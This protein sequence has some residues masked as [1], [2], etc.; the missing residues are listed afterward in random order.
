MQDV[1][2]LTS[3]TNAGVERLKSDGHLDKLRRWL[4]PSDPSTNL[5]AA[6]GKRLEGTGNWFIN[7][8]AFSQ[9]KSGSP[10]HLWL[11]GLAGCGKT[12]LTS[13]ILDHLHSA[14]TDSCVCL[15]FF[16]DFR[17]KDKQHLDNLLRSLASQLYARCAESRQELDSLFA[18]CENG[19]MQPTIELLSKTV[20]LMMQ[21]PQK[22]RIVL[23]A[24]DECAAR[25][26]LLEWMKTLAGPALKNVHLIAT[27]RREE[28]L[29]SGLQWIDKENTI[30]LQGDLIDND[31]RSYTKARLQGPGAFQKRWGEKLDV[32][33]E[34]ETVI[35]EKSKG[36]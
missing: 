4:S 35:G 10:Q 1:H 17:D 31:I 26:E 6:R 18:S 14:P 33:E 27:S 32:L 19:Q 9:W 29:E 5:N 12:V 22:V 2:S 23:D 13:T 7:S 15:D 34:I 28:E 11:H 25:S 30:P 3:H 20:H 8:D 16:F 24:L 21:R 36:M